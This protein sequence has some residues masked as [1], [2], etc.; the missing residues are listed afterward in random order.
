MTWKKELQL[1]S[2][3]IFLHAPEWQL[4]LMVGAEPKQIILINSR[5]KK[6]LIS[7]RH[8]CTECAQDF[9]FFSA[10]PKDRPELHLP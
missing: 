9:K 1:Q 3:I 4:C 5:V 2:I 8:R 6:I 7:K 10:G